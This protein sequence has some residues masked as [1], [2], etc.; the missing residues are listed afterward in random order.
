M[1]GLSHDIIDGVPTLKVNLGVEI[2]AAK[3]VIRGIVIAVILLTED[4]LVIF[5]IPYG[6]SPT[7]FFDELS[8]V[9]TLRIRRRK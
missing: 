9:A 5:I 2:T 1:G 6:A 3:I 7:V 8:P 4:L